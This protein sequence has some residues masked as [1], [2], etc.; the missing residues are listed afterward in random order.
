MFELQA[1]ATL[2]VIY[3]LSLFSCYAALKAQCRGACNMNHYTYNASEICIINNV[4]QNTNK[5]QLQASIQ[6]LPADSKSREETGK[7]S[8][9]VPLQPESVSLSQNARKSITLLCI[10]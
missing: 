3:L 9:S 10:D 1:I 6:F 2:I 8:D 5:N 4:C 7:T